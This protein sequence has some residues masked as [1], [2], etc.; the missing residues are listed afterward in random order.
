MFEFFS[1]KGI[2]GRIKWRLMA[3]TRRQAVLTFAGAPASFATDNKA[4]G[5]TGV[6]ILRVPHAG[7]Q[8]QTAVDDRGALHVLYYAGDAHAGDIFYVRSTDRGA[9]FSSPVRVNSEPG[10]AIAAGTIR[11][12]QLALGKNRRVHVVWNGSGSAQPK[13]P[14]N[15]D[16]GKPGSPMLYTRLDGTSRGFEPQ[17]G[18]MQHS[19]GLDGGGSIAADRDGN[20]YVLWH[21]IGLTEAKGSGNGEARRRVFVTRS[22]NDGD[23]FATERAA[24]SLRTGACGC[25]GM[26]AHADRQGNLWALYRSATESVHRD[27][28]LLNSENHGDSFEGRLLHKWEINACPMSS[29]DIADNGGRVVAAWETGGQIYWT[30]LDGGNHTL[31]APEGEPKGRKH[32]RVAINRSGEVLLV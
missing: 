19:F 1:I 7:I 25:C 28:Y 9:S 27:I 8:P 26:K 30:R 32:P 11:G 2:Q 31:L 14:I 5:Q 12:A 20:V 23:T 10:S 3:L 4:G 6:R 18:V 29:M 13:G 22:E 15:P 24:W 16:A 17:R 21:G